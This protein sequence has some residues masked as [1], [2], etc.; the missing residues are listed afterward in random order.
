VS[1]RDSLKAAVRLAGEHHAAIM[2][3]VEMKLQEKLLLHVSKRSRGLQGG[4][5]GWERRGARALR[6]RVCGE[7]T[8]VSRRVGNVSA[9]DRVAANHS[10]LSAW[11]V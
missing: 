7:A 8:P 1:S 3:R 11:A 5:H 2:V 10:L 9:R 4:R 6:G